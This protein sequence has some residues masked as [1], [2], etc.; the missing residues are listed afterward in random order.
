MIASI[1]EAR[2]YVKIALSCEKNNPKKARLLYLKASECYLHN[3]K[4]QENKMYFDMAN[5]LFTKAQSFKSKQVVSKKQAGNDSIKPYRNIAIGFDD[6]FGLE[7]A[8]RKIR[9]KIIL[10]FERPDIY[11]IYKKKA[12]GGILFWGPP[13]CGKTLLAEAT[14]K[15][16][17]AVFYNIKIS[18][19]LSKW[20][21][22]SEKTITD[23]FKRAAKEP[24]V[25]FF[26]ELDALGGERND[27]DSSFEKRLTN[28]ILSQIDGVGT[29]KNKI[30]I[31]GA[32]NTPWT[33]DTA[34]RRPGRFDEIVFISPPNEKAQKQIIAHQLKGTPVS[35]NLNLNYI[36][37][38]T[39]GFSG[40]DIVALAN[41]AVN[42]PL[43][44][45]LEGKSIRP[46]NTGDFMEALEKRKSSLES[47]FSKAK[48]QIIKA[49][50][51]DIFKEVFNY[52][53]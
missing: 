48:T 26:D 44:E 34:L 8:K 45:A 10:P 7:E 28:H 20:V 29:K 5:Y 51:E 12:G 14:A 46:T 32:T 31:L 6:I 13:G 25:L 1:A 41:D 2:G 35:R 39:V 50:Q 36:A 43:R 23:I 11:K 15:E 22:E 30:L 37:Q 52:A 33:I 21:G 18:D 3:A 27:A 42:I 17:K 47:W 24:S 4:K 16:A 19:I 49:Q 53:H 38:K 9:E 40:A